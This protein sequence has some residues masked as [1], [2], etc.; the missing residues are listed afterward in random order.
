M[1]IG[2]FGGAFDPPHMG[3]VLVA[4]YALQSTDLNEVWVVPT[5]KH[6]FGKKMSPF[7][8]RWQMCLAAFQF[9]PKIKVSDYERDQQVTCTWELFARLQDQWPDD[10]FYLILGTDEWASFPTWFKSPELAKMVAGFIVVGR[11]GIDTIHDAVKM[12]ALS[13]TEIRNNLAR[14]ISPDALQGR[15]PWHVI[16]M[17]KAKGLYKPNPDDLVIAERS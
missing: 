5:Y 6:F 3:H 10:E 7:E 13:S 17:I 16:E 2:I 15:V 4:T 8:A 9:S 11:E 1:K 14:G 12:P